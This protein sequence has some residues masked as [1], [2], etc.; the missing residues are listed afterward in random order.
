M[1]P[2]TAPAEAIKE[3]DGTGHRN[4]IEPKSPFGKTTSLGDEA[5]NEARPGLFNP[6]VSPALPPSL[7][8]VSKFPEPIR[9]DPGIWYHGNLPTRKPPANP[10]CLVEVLPAL[11]SISALR[12]PQYIEQAP[13]MGVPIQQ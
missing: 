2:I 4:W 6:C 8:W 9:D 13:E 12:T 3:K 7:P 1:L 11:V 10:P 5:E